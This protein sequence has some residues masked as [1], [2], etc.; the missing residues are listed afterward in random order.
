MRR[1]ILGFVALGMAASPALAGDHWHNFW[2]S[3][4]RDFHR[5][6]CW[7]DPFVYPDR[8]AVQSALSIQV[9]NGWKLQ[10]LMADHHF[11]AS[12]NELT[13]AGR[14]KVRWILTQAPERYRTVFVQKAT[15]GELTSARVDSVQKVAVA[16]LPKGELPSVE[17]SNMAPRGWPA[18]EINETFVK[19]RT[20]ARPPQLPEP[21]SE[22]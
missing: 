15:T 18:E 20:T 2:H 17:E 4:G 13:A 16:I 14:E 21:Q 22:D 7:P 12:T 6:N 19:Y 8:A 3:V 10:N 9:Q 5:N 11:D 1:I